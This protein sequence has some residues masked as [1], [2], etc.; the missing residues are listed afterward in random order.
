LA[1]VLSGSLD[2]REEAMVLYRRAQVLEPNDIIA[3]NGL[4][5]LLSKDSE[6][7]AEAGELLRRALTIQPGY[8]WALGNLAVVLAARG[9]TGALEE[10]MQLCERAQLLLLFAK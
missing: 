10:A 6:R 1:F 3:L 9:D 5:Y 2:T 7:L 4:G 8:C